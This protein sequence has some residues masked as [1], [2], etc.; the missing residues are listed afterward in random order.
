MTAIHPHPRVVAVD[1]VPMSALVAEA[2]QPNPR[3]AL[4]ASPRFVVN[5]QLGEGHNLSL[6]YS[7]AA[8][9]LKVLS[10]AEDCPVARQD[11]AAES[12]D[13]DLEAG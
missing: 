9:H 3:S 4:P 10:F 11:A 1:G 6:G 8:Y 2:P 7:A 13:V 5:E 12:V